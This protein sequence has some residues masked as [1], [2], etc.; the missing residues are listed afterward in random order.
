MA[1]DYY[2]TLFRATAALDPD[3]A[4]ARRAVYDRAR[5]AIMDAGLS[6]TETNQ[7]RAAIEEAIRGIEA[8]H[9][10]GRVLPPAPDAR[11]V[12]A[13]EPELLRQTMARSWAVA[14][15]ITAMA[16]VIAVVVWPRG[17]AN[18]DTGV[19]QADAGGT[20][21]STSAPNSGRAPAAA[22]VQDGPDA[23]YIHKRQLVYYRSIH[24]PGTVVIAKSQRFLYVVR[25]DIVA[26]RYT[27]AVGRECSNAIGL[28]LVSAK[29]EGMKD[30]QP[31]RLASADTG[32]TRSAARSLALGDTGHR[33]YGTDGP[34]TTAHDGCFALVSDDIID[35][36]DRVAVGTRVVIN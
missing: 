34:L 18:R 20:A 15:A 1:R 6:T 33:I 9:A 25:P 5:L 14:L 35:L 7:E 13:P 31:A 12:P 29:D 28:L 19:N 30:A 16:L 24:P 26:M 22:G 36:Y 8:A 27:I 2:S 10:Q 3:T 23:S 21:T 17:R 11:Q 32:K 4:E